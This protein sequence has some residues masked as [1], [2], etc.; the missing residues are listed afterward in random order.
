MNKPR[1]FTD[2]VLKTGLNFILE[3]HH[4]IHL[5]FK[6]T[7]TPK[8]LYSEKFQVISFIKDMAKIYARLCS[9]NKIINQ[10]LFSVRFGKQDEVDQV[11]DGIEFY[12]IAQRLSEI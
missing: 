9:Q 4:F 5:I 7:V 1:H 11:L 12:I 2:K 3:S 10:T 8:N 6:L